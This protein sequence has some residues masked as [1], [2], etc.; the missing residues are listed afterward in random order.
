MNTKPFVTLAIAVTV[1]TSLAT[2]A[3]AALSKMKMTTD[4]PGGDCDAGQR[5]S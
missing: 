4:I 1:A 3:W 2:T 5:E